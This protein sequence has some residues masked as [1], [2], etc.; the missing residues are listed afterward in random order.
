MSHNSL[1]AQSS[2]RRCRCSCAGLL[3]GYTTPHGS[4]AR[5]GYT[6]LTLV[7]AGEPG[8]PRRLAAGAG[9][10]S[11]LRGWVR[12][13]RRLAATITAV[14]TDG[15]WQTVAKSPGLDQGHLARSEHALC[16]L[17]AAMAMQLDSTAGD[18][19]GQDGILA[20]LASASTDA[21]VDGVFGLIGAG[22]L[23]DVA[24]LVRI[25]ALATCPDVEWHPE[26]QRLA[27]GDGATRGLGRLAGRPQAID[28]VP[29]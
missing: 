2:S 21:V 14:A 11:Y 20:E 28:P 17:F 10:S 9:T 5:P 4:P 23:D 24:T 27:S 25:A 8:R 18:P 22:Q 7:G 26:V 13:H 16:A 12:T 15:V 1:C 29:A 3:H 6:Q 19:P